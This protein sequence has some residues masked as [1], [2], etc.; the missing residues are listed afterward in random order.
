MLCLFIHINLI[1]SIVFIEV[2]K[3]TH[4]NHSVI[5]IYCAVAIVKRVFRQV[6]CSKGVIKAQLESLMLYYLR[7][8]ISK[9]RLVRIEIFAFHQSLNNQK[10]YKQLYPRMTL[11]LLQYTSLNSLEYPQL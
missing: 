2:Y 4:F 10:E 7:I 3:P 5:N 1:R 8:H 6:I 11:G 9:I